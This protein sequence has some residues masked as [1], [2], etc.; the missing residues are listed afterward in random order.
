MKPIFTPIK[1]RRRTD[2]FVRCFAIA[3]CNFQPPSYVDLDGGHCAKVPDPSFR[4]ISRD[5][6]RREARYIFAS[7]AVLFA[8]IMLMASVAIASGAVAAIDFLRVLGYL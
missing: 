6:F 8:L 1:S 7:E 5:Y 3:D 2:C 4:N